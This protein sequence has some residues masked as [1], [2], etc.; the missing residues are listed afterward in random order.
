MSRSALIRTS[1]FD[2]TSQWLRNIDPAKIGLLGDRC[3]I[4]D[5]PED[6]KAGSLWI[7][8]MCQNNETL[9][10]GIVVA[11]G[12]G[13]NCIEKPVDDRRIT[14]DGRPVLKRKSVTQPCP[15]IATGD[16]VEYVTGPCLICGGDG[17]IP[18]RLPMTVRL[19]DR[20][21]YTR[22]RDEEFYVNGERISLV[23]E[24][25]AVLAVLT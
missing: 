6:E 9:R 15:E 4:R 17:K 14:S 23:H 5:L 2:E 7:P 19:G 13:D 3:L 1:I 22:R 12:P 18:G 8:E 16:C 25:Q 10:Q 20:V 11:V 24:Q 21:L